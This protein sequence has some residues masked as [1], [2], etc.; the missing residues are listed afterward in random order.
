MKEK[1]I[2]TAWEEVK[3]HEKLDYDV[4]SSTGCC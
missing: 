4:G 3:E 1:W 2:V